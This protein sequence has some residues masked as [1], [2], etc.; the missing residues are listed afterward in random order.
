MSE[1]N[2]QEIVRLSRTDLDGY[3]TIAEGLTAIKGVGKRYANAVARKS[4]FE[5][6]RKIGGLSDDER[7]KLKEIMENPDDYDIPSYLRNRRKDMETGEDIH[8]VGPE[9]EL[10]EDFDIRRLKE[11][12][13]YRGWRHKIGLP[14]RGQKTQSSFRTGSKVGVS[15]SRVKANA[16][17]DSGE[18]EE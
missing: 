15:R 14:V 6:D 16:E 18:D 3:R 13:T 7:D 11:T 12:G 10:K 5:M 9:L 2:I 1:E 17:E 8:L 4:P